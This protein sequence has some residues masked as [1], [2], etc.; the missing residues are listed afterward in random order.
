[1]KQLILISILMVMSF[2][3]SAQML[4]TVQMKEKVEGICD[5]SRVFALYI[6]FKGQVPAKCPIS[7]EEIE[8]QLNDNL[9]FLKENPKFKSKGMVGLYVNCKGEPLKWEIEVKTKSSDARMAPGNIYRHLSELAS[10][11]RY[12]IVIPPKIKIKIIT[13]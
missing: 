10:P 7:K 12:K 13:H 4:A 8:K 1:M 11:W 5:S 3:S 9:T 6:G 2:T